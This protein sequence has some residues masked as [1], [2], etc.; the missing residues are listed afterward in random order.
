LFALL[1]YCSLLCLVSCCSRRSKPPLPYL[2]EGGVE[3]GGGVVYRFRVEGIFSHFFAFCG[4][5]GS[6]AYSIFV[7][8]HQ[9]KEIFF[10]LSLTH[11]HWSTSAREKK[12]FFYFGEPIWVTLLGNSKITNKTSQFESLRHHRVSDYVL[13]CCHNRSNYSA[14]LRYVL[15]SACCVL[16]ANKK[17][18][19]R[20]KCWNTNLTHT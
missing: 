6:C 2:G 15:A 11:L 19:E 9:I 10:L 4:H 18:S 7:M 14:C 13:F 12:V 8:V 3:G 20:G 17:L 16:S 5:F 1:G